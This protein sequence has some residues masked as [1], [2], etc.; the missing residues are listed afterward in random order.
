MSCFHLQ[1]VWC[2]AVLGWRVCF[3]LLR[4][5]LMCFCVW[6]PAVLF[7]CAVLSLFVLCLAVS[8]CAVPFAVAPVLLAFVRFVWSAGAVPPSPVVAP[9]FVRCPASCCVVPRCG[10]S[11]FVWFTVFFCDLLFCAGVRVPC[12]LSVLTCCAVAFFAG[13]LLLRLAALFLLVLCGAL[14]RRAL[15]CDGLWCLLA[16]CVVV[17]CGVVFGAVWC[18]GA[19][20]HLVSRCV[21]LRCTCCV[22]LSCYAPTLPLLPLLWGCALR[23]VLLCRV[24]LCARCCAALGWCACIVLF[25]AGSICG[26]SGASCCGVLL[27]AVLFPLAFCGAVVLPCCVMWC[28]VVPCCLVLCPV[29]LCC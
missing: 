15:W 1:C 13:R 17:C 4:R 24:L 27:H 22:G 29:E 19:L 5:T 2:C 18:L 14:L 11:C 10:V 28:V 9:G 7:W 16:S 8:R 26:L 3:L 25:C 21:L 20:C 23:A 6:S 12:C